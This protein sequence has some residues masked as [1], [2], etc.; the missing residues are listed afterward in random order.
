LFFIDAQ[1]QK[2]GESKETLILSATAK[3]SSGETPIQQKKF[4]LGKTD[5]DNL[6]KAK[7]IVFVGKINSPSNGAEVAKI[8]STNKLNINVAISSKV[9]L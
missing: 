2:I 7:G 4:E 8:F 5:M 6:R 3:N 9:N 1:N